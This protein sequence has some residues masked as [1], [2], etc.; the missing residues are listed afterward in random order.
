MKKKEIKRKSVSECLKLI[1]E[2]EIKENAIREKS[3][4]EL[5]D[6]ILEVFNKSILN[7]YLGIR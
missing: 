7:D 4:E 2:N 5:L 6:F 3:K 1:Y